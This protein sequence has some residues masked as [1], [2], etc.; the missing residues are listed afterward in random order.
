MLDILNDFSFDELINYA[1]T[2]KNFQNLISWIF[3][4]RKYKLNEKEIKLMDHRSVNSS[5]QFYENSVY[6]LHA[7]T[8]MKILRNFGHLI[9]N[10]IVLP[11][12]YKYSE[13][14]EPGSKIIN[15][16]INKYCSKSLKNLTLVNFKQNA[17]MEWFKPFEQVETVFFQVGILD[18]KSLDLNKIFPKIRRLE[19]QGVIVTDQ[20]FIEQHFAYLH[21]IIIDINLARLNRDLWE[22]NIKKFIQLNPQLRKLQLRTFGERELFTLLSQQNLESL[23]LEVQPSDFFSQPGNDSLAHF[24]HVKKLTLIFS[25]YQEYR[26]EHLPFD[27]ENIEELTMNWFHD[28]SLTREWIDFV[29]KHKNIRKLTLQTSQPRDNHWAMMLNQLPHL[30]ELHTKLSIPSAGILNFIQ[31]SDNVTKYVF[32]AIT[33]RNANELIALLGDAWQCTSNERD[34]LLTIVKL[35]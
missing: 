10:L 20:R 3:S 19:F 25:L 27:F 7:T 26:I 29:I 14:L 6:I 32:Y 16:Y 23:G 34:S 35:D 17:T 5:T 15:G 2:D 21:E 22:S 9:T 13:Y 12:Y 33:K 1:D 30:N 31:N 11:L 4:T 28:F 18:T 8:A 24:P